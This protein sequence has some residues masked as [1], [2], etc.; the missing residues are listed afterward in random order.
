[1]LLKQTLKK[2][3]D[4]R[5][6]LVV[7]KECFAAYLTEVSSLIS[8]NTEK[9]SM[10][11]CD[12]EVEF[13]EVMVQHFHQPGNVWARAARDLKKDA[14]V[15]YADFMHVTLVRW[16]QLETTTTTTTTT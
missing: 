9:R 16:T 1:L 2:D 8:T 10:N 13:V 11:I 4:S 7:A 3:P 12:L 5:L 6:V 15:Q 14:K